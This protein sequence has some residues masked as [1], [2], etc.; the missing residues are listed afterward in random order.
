M[1][2]S[3]ILCAFTAERWSHLLDALT[4]V[5]AQTV[6]AVET[7]LVIDHNQALLSKARATLKTHNFNPPPN[8][9]IIGNSG[10]K[11]LSGSRNSGVAA[12]K[13]DVIAFLDD[14]AV[15]APGWLEQITSSYHSAQ[16]VLGVGG[17]ASPLWPTDKPAWFPEEFL[18]V[19]GCSHS[20]TPQEAMSVRNFIGCNMSFRREVLTAVG[21]FRTEMGRVGKRPTGCEETELCIRVS[22]QLSG[23]LLFNPHARVLHQVSAPRTTLRYFVRRCYAEGLSK[24]L[25]ARTVGAQDALAT[26]R[27]YTSK[28]LP[29]GIKRGVTQALGHNTQ[30]DLMGAARAASI[31]LGLSVT[32][33]GYLVGRLGGLMGAAPKR[34]HEVA[35]RADKE[36]P[37]FSPVKVL[38]L[39][40]SEPLPD[41]SEQDGGY[42]RA[43]ILVRADHKPLGVLETQL[44]PDLNAQALAALIWSELEGAI[45]AQFDAEIEV[46]L[47]AEG[48]SHTPPKPDTAIST[49]F[50]SIIIATHNR[51]QSLKMGLNSL[52]ELEYPHY[53]VIV[54]DNA[55]RDAETFDLLRRDYPAVHYVRE[56]TPGLA[57]AHNSGL[58]E[59]RGDI[60]AFTDDDVQVDPQWLGALVAGFAVQSENDIE[61]GCVTGMITPAELETPAQVWLEQYG[62]FSKGFEQ[63]I[64]DL[65]HHRPPSP[66]YPYTAGVFGSGANMAFKR[67][68]LARL[69]GFDPALGAG[70]KGVGGDDLAAFFDVVSRGYALVYQPEAVV[71]HRHRRDYAGLQRTAYGYG[72][73]LSAFLTKCLV[74]KPSRLLTILPLI[75]RALMYALSPTSPK[76]AKK[77]SDYPGELNGLERRGMLYGPLAYLRSRWALRCL[78]RSSPQQTL[79]RNAPSR[80]LFNRAS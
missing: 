23:T 77:Q 74:D 67:E 15:A 22:Q 71:R 24:A 8:L 48:L 47:D 3:V 58:A 78:P 10:K 75:P 39:D 19:V 72:V 16:N 37:A 36:V 34:A 55:P 26:E 32:A 57:L 38:D 2:I 14:D 43:S 20:G 80:S 79:R 68:A 50:V 12:A 65:H 21:P 35:Q 45:R 42:T 54:V 1:D 27:A 69:G 49:P 51:A 63:R 66:L 29:Q 44:T 31:I 61:V 9:K 76:N 7:I 62:G 56:E 70:S 17:A 40:I 52:A 18:W 73:G 5:E 13:G 41:L 30:R 6:S 64:F 46:Q 28:V 4:S 33:A 53:E 11:G 59:A 60:V 25:V